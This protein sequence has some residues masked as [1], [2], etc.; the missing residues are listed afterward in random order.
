MSTPEAPD[1]VAMTIPQMGVVADVVV[2][3]WLVES[4]ARVEAGDEVVLVETEKAEVALEC[5]A[6]GIIEVVT[7]AS[8]DEVPVGAT[9]AYISP[10]RVPTSAS[11]GG[12]RWS[13][14]PRAAWG[15]PPPR[16]WPHPG[17]MWWPWTWPP[18]PTG[19][20]PSGSVATR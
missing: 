9:I 7:A 15:E 13:P 4:G 10:G 16:P 1:R 12:W 5:P 8:E 11:T 18:T 14:A 20:W 2:L 3:E 6:S 17:R 19:R